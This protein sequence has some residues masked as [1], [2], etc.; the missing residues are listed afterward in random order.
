MRKKLLDK[1]V[2]WYLNSGLPENSWDITQHIVKAAEYTYNT[3]L[4]NSSVKYICIRNYGD[5]CIYI[6]Q[7]SFELFKKI[8]DVFNEEQELVNISNLMKYTVYREMKSF[9][10]DKI[11]PPAVKLKSTIQCNVRGITVYVIRLTEL[12]QEEELYSDLISYN[13][14]KDKYRLYEENN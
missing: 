1:L 11:S 13:I 7:D 10:A 2:S 12:Y 6:P 4:E 5:T 3:T 8:K 14:V 9:I